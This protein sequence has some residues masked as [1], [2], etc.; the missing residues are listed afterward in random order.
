[1]YYNFARFHNTLRVTPA[2]EA[3]IDNNLWTVEE[4][5]NLA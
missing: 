4:I 3:G 2:L 1:M 5:A